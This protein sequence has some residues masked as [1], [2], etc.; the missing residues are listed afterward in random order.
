MSPGGRDILTRWRPRRAGII[1][2]YEYADQ[3]FDFAGGRLLLRGHNTSGKTKALEVLF[4]FCLDG[5]VSPKKLDPF[6]AGYK[7]MKWNLVGCTGHDKRVG[8]VW[9]EFERLDERGAAQRL[10]AGIGMRGHQQQSDVARWFFIARNRA[11]GDDLSLLTGRNPLSKAELAAALGDDGEVMDSQRDYRARLNDLLFGFTGEEQYQTMLRLM[12]DLRRPH[13]SKTLDPDRVAAQLTV[14]LPEVD[15]GLMRKLAGGLEQLETLERNLARLRDVRERVRRFHQRTYSAYARAVIRE[16]ADALRQAHTA[17]DTAAEVVRAT[18]AKLAAERTR[19]GDATERRD[20]AD[21]DLARLSAERD[22]LVTSEAW[23]SIAEVE[24]LREHAATQSRAAA[25]ARERGEAAA[26]DAGG[27]E[28]ELITAEA[29][30]ADRRKQAGAE[31]DVAT[32]LADRAGLGPRTG[33]LAQQLRDDAVTADTWTRL[34]RELATDWRDVLHRH[35]ALLIAAR[36]ASVAAE[37]AR[38]HE[39]AAAERREQT[40]RCRTACEQE[41]EDGRAAIGAELSRWRDALDELAVDDATFEEALALVH[42]GKPAAPA[43]AE[44]A[45]RRRTELATDRAGHAAARAAAAQAVEETEAEITRL[46]AAQDD[47]PPAPAWARAERTGRPGAP[48]W[49]LVDFRDE[50]SAEQRTGLEAALEASGLL[51][52]WITPTGQLEDA[53]VADVLLTEAAPAADRSL[54][55]ALTPVADQPVAAEVVARLLAGLGLGSRPSGP[56]VDF[57]GRFDIG[58]LNGRGAKPQADH[59]GAA[60]RAARRAARVAELRTRIESLQ[61]QIGRHDEQIAEIDRRRG[62]LEAELSALPP[63]DA[64]AAVIDALRVATALEAEASRAHE[65]ASLAAREAADAELAADAARREHAAAHGLHGALDEAALDERRDAAAELAG[66]AG[67][68]GG[69]WALAERE[70]RAA[71]VLA[72]RLGDARQRATEAAR[73]AEAEA[74]EAIRLTAEHAERE[75]SL[76]AT[77]EELRRRHAEVVAALKTH[78]RDPPR[79]RRHR[80]AGA[81]RGRRARARRAELRRRA[82]AGPQPARAGERRVPAAG[83]GRHPPAGAARGHASGRRHGRRLDGDADARGGPGASRGAAGGPHRL[84][85]AGGGGRSAPSS[86]STASSPRPT[87]PPMPPAARTA[88]CSSR[89]PTPAASRRSPRCSRR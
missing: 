46:Q 34:V 79:R 42:T 39:R 5:D 62:A 53:A 36:Q 41:L 10:T 80:A 64:I 23:S 74:T 87:W 15:Q 89:S 55:A 71:S 81:D 26:A 54:L 9:L 16:R 49:Q 14:G 58:P 85:R 76:G 25:S 29:A 30:T 18:Q 22:A 4:P 57:D 70:A 6:G 12:R 31:L 60:A 8:Y 67:A 19:A 56:W 66:A 13:L 32:A 7:D 84:R 44:P 77:G 61:A 11:V 82:R 40:A 63:V 21:A 48:L 37:R 38:E 86:C 35:R 50:L 43:L 59:I 52:A 83:A 24:A 78:P 73:R 68:V 33:I 72:E 88:C 20:A 75:R 45:D 51:D 65:Q 1:G 47:G 2:L 27:L 69:V 17:V 28:A 3:V